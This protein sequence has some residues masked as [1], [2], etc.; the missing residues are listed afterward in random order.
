[1][2]KYEIKEEQHEFNGRVMT[3]LVCYIKDHKFVLAPITPSKRARAL[4]YA[5]LTNTEKVN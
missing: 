5:L 2:P 1:M 4:F 3:D